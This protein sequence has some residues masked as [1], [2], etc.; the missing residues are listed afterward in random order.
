MRLDHPVGDLACRPPLV[1]RSQDVMERRQLRD[2]DA[3]VRH[4][5]DEKM[6]A[7]SHTGEALGIA[8]ERLRVL[9]GL[10]QSLQIHGRRSFR[11]ELGRHGLER[12]LRLDHL[13]VRPA[14]QL[15]LDCERVS[16]ALEVPLGDASPAS[17]P[18]THLDDSRGGERSKRVA[19]SHAADPELLRERRL[20]P[21]KI[22]APDLALE[23]GL[24]DR[25]GDV[26]RQRGGA[27]RWES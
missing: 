22:T 4:F 17:R 7:E 16:E 26:A 12:R 9:D 10:P 14:E 21:E 5:R 6:K 11:G 2:E 8:D 20:R 25:L 13:D 15:E 1:Q 24:P 27:R 3:V 23:Q 19:R 18:L